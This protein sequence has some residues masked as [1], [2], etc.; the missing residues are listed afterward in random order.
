MSKYL[1]S[2]ERENIDRNKIQGFLLGES[3]EYILIRYVYDFNLDG[4]MVLRK[5]DI[6]RVETSKTDEFQTQLL[7]DEGIY[8]QIDF[9]SKYDV[10]SLKS[11]IV[12]VVAEKYKHFIVEA[13]DRDEPDF[14]IGTIE[15]IGNKSIV[16]KHFTGIGRWI[17]EPVEINYSDI[18]SLQVG[19]NYLNVYERHFRRGHV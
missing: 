19:S 15:K 9:N 17:D 13:E 11:L 14:T 10:T 18:T 6:S 7:K 2:I 3:D 5:K 16:M 12:S 1:V 8:E 4:L